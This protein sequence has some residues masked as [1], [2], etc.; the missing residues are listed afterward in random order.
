MALAFTIKDKKEVSDQF[1]SFALGLFPRSFSEDWR[2]NP[3][4][5][6]QF[7][8]RKDYRKLL[9]QLKGE[10]IQ[11]HPAL[12]HLASLE[13]R[14]RR[15]LVFNRGVSR[16]KNELDSKPN[17]LLDRALDIM[18]ISDDKSRFYGREL[19]R[20][21]GLPRFNEEHAYELVQ[22][23]ISE[24]DQLDDSNSQSQN[25]FKNIVLQIWLLS[26]EAVKDCLTK[27]EA[28][29]SREVIIQDRLQQ[30]RSLFAKTLQDIKPIMVFANEHLEDFNDL[31]STFGEL[32]LKDKK[33]YL[34]KAAIGVLDLYMDSLERRNFINRANVSTAG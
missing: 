9:F 20:T 17:W 2:I 18:N 12:L 7:K 8:K 27:T 23:F 22:R 1:R 4:S 34:I 10:L 32:K 30:S 21:L 24:L 11:N 16:S 14:D 5:Q 15:N 29:S 28:N 6:Q 3:Q 13:G 26:Y 19:I 31:K 33:L 25:N